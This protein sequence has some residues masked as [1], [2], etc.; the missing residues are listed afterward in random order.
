MPIKLEILVLANFATSTKSL[1]TRPRIRMA[2]GPD[3]TFPK[4]FKNPFANVL[5]IESPSNTL[6][7]PLANPSTAFNIFSIPGPT[8]IEP[9]CS[10]SF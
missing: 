3:I 2:P 6:E 10:E 5:P 8:V 7:I 4:P 9:I 1:P